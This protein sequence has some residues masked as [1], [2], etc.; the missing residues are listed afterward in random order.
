MAVIDARE[1]SVDA[2]VSELLGS[3]V[4]VVVRSW[5][6][7]GSFG[8]ILDEHCDVPI[9]VILE[10]GRYRAESTTEEPM[11]SDLLGETSSCALQQPHGRN[12]TSYLETYH[13]GAAPKWSAHARRGT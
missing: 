9:D 11:T 7:S 6:D 8:H 10:G 3:D 5:Q 4:P 12:Q 2:L 1:L 13:P